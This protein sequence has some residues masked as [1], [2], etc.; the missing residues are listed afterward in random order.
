[1]S[2]HVEKRRNF[3]SELVFNIEIRTQNI[4]KYIVIILSWNM[5][6]ENPKQCIYMYKKTIG[7]L[8]TSHMIKYIV[9]LENLKA[10][11]LDSFK[12][13]CILSDNVIFHE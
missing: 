7:I 3:Q 6:R 1:M 5:M 12:K 9:R 2:Q 8:N 4:E 10:D 11:Q 13:F